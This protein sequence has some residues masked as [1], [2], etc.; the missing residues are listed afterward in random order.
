MNKAV[1]LIAIFVM[2]LMYAVPA[3]AETY[4]IPN[5]PAFPSP[6]W[7]SGFASTWKVNI[8]KGSENID[9]KLRMAIVGA[10]TA[11][12]GTKLYWLETDITDIVGLPS[13]LEQ[14]LTYYNGAPPETIRTNMLIP[15]YDLTRIITDPSKAYKDITAPGFIRKIYFQYNR[16]TPYDVDLNLLNGLLIPLVA[17]DLL[18][19]NIPEDFATNRNLGIRMEKSDE[20]Y[21]TEVSSGQTS[22]AAGTFSGTKIA[23]TA[24]TEK[25]TNGLAFVSEALGI[26]PI[27]TLTSVIIGESG[28]TDISL[29]LVEK[30]DSGA[31]TQI[32]GEPKILDFTTMMS[33]G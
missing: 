18:G 7:N 24:K 5:F 26:L 3:N 27:V 11:S 21:K 9:F 8:V 20:H 2:V 10:E 14:L 22:C 12:D 16:Q 4:Y 6:S 15:Q 30:T 33:G 28:N 1:K 32:V 29:E 31:K 17:Q 13:D 25:G 23:Y 19:S